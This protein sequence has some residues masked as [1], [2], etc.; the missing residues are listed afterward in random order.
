MFALHDEGVEA[1][2][3]SEFLLGMS[4]LG[5]DFGEFGLDPG[6]FA[7]EGLGCG[8]AGF[9]GREA[10]ADVGEAEDGLEGFEGGWRL[11]GGISGRGG[12][13]GGFGRRG[14]ELAGGVGG[15][16]GEV[17]IGLEAQGFEDGVEGAD[18]ARV[19]EPFAEDGGGGPEGGGWAAGFAE[20]AKKSCLEIRGIGDARHKGLLSKGL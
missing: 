4:E 6:E 12:V 8:M 3:E 5:A 17:E 9:D 18:E 11:I 15:G 20:G 10:L 7:G 2:A 16:G 14:G 1:D 19:A 13:V